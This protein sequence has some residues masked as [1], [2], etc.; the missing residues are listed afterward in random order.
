MTV[1]RPF[2]LA[3]LDGWGERASRDGN[4]I[5]QAR[6]PVL[7]A[8]RRDYPTTVL[9]ASGEAVGLPEG[10]MGNSEVGHL[11]IGAGRVVLQDFMRINRAVQDGT[12][13]SNEVLIGAMEH[14]LETRGTLHLMGLLSDGGVH[15]H[16]DHLIALLD[17]AG[18]L[19]LQKVCTHAFLDGRDV[20]PRSALEWV[21]QLEERVGDAGIGSIRTIQG[22]YYAMDRDNRWDRT[23]LAYDAVARAR[24]PVVASAEE[25][26]TRSYD[27]GIDDEF[28]V[29]RVVG[30]PAP[31]AE[32]D[33]VIFF[34]FRPDRPR[35]LTH[36]IVDPDF[37]EF[38]RGS[39]PVIPFLVTMTEYDDRFRVPFAFPPQ[40]ITNVLAD[41]LAAHGK[42]QLHIAETEKYAHVTY[43]FNG[44]V[45]EPKHGE[46]RALVPSPRVATY[47]LK[48]EMSAMEVAAET[49][50]RIDNGAYDFI[51]L[52]FANGDMVGHTGS[53]E[54][55]VKAVEVVDTAVG[56]VMDA[57]LDAGGAA[58]ITGDHGNAE[59]MSEDG[60]ICTAHSCCGVPFINVTPDRRRLRSGGTL[61][62]IAP[63]VL[64]VMELPQPGEMTGRTLFVP[65]A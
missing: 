32:Q 7:D 24:A 35:Q 31:M 22:R 3:I 36:A 17:M 29:P 2:L 38:D 63:T 58:F 56:R 27:D 16:I 53:M 37:G 13:F 21:R 34:N 43:F 54:A 51:V 25:A 64:E 10:Q 47:D 40:Q 20:P 15:S 44:G 12:F 62:D 52:N 5:A 49:V 19:G 46:D 45:E 4:A 39:E 42:T 30:D 41:V 6:K 1:P 18:R 48:P 28:V 60:Q 59:L 26:V 55:T 33:S 50:R 65:V 57:L 8:L 23:A 11:N 9:G 61:G 14:A